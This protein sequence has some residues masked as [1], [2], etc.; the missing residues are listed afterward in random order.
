MGSW[1]LSC[2]AAHGKITRPA[3]LP[4]D[5]SLFF[6]CGGDGFYNALAGFCFFYNV[7]LIIELCDHG[8][9]RRAARHKYQGKDCCNYV[10]RYVFH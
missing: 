1:V 7:S 8:S 3:I 5:H 9:G 6:G 4:H 2:S 10:T